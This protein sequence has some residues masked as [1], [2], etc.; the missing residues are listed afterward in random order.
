MAT[1]RKSATSSTS[2]AKK[3]AAKKTAA[4]KATTAKRT[5]AKKAP[6]RKSTNSARSESNGTP[7]ESAPTKKVPAM[8]VA[9]IAAQQLSEL[10]GREPECVIGIRR[11]DDGW[12]V[13]LEVVESRRIPDSTDILATYEVQTDEDGDLMGYQRVRRYVRG[14][15]GDGDG[16]RR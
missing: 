8:K 3:T 11:T 4:K 15:G 14:K 1:A 5:A 12:Q 13:E 16:G 7:S 9:R 6:A 10:T 2:A